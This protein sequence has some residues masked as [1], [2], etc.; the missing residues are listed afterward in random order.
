MRILMISDHADP[1]AVI[2]SKESGGQNVYVMNIASRLANLGHQVDVYTRWDSRKK[3]EVVAVNSQ[4][5]VIRVNAG[6]RGYMP[7]DNFLSVTDDFA[8]EIKKRITKERLIY[9]VIF[10][11]YWFSGIIGMDIAKAF[12]LPQTHVYHSIGQIR[13][14]ALK[15]DQSQQIDLEFFDVRNEWEKRIAHTA[16]SV[17]ATSP[18]EKSEIVRLFNVDES[19]IACIPIGVDM[20]MFKPIPVNKLREKLGLPLNKSVVLY[21]GRIEW[22]KGIGTLIRAL[23][24]LPKTAE[25][26]IVGGGNGDDDL[27]TPERKRLANIAKNLRLVRRVH[28][29]GAKTQDEVTQYYAAADV[30]AVPSYYEPFGIVPL[31]AMACGTPV[32]ASKTGGL[33]FTVNHGVTGYLVKPNNSVDL[34]EKLSLVLEKGR[35]AYSLL[36]REHVRQNFSW[37]KIAADTADYLASLATL[38]NVST[39]REQLITPE[40]KLR[41]EKS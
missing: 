9:D 19:R 16:T 35:A 22:R 5:R 17:L 41:A 7:R 12:N 25:L 33:Q 8:N 11:H 30:C 20:K 39:L 28:F 15:E 34:A 6:P 21:V 37:P 2:G 10:S 38:A 14:D 3:D 29:L 18:V 26:Y 24:S 23:A 1:L 32:V 36:A 40:V 4:F 13:R 31:E 27:D